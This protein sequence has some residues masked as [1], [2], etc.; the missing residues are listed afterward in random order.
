[1]SLLNSL[2][3]AKST[4]GSK[5]ESHEVLLQSMSGTITGDYGDYRKVSFGNA[6]YNVDDK[7]VSGAMLFKPNAKATITVNQYINKEGV[8]KTIISALTIQAP[9]GSGLFIMR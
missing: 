7:R 3:A 6:T 5:S 1:M 2:S 9:D 4:E 8:E